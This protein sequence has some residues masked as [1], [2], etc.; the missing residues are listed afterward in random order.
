MKSENPS[1]AGLA[2]DSSES[3]TPGQGSL[4]ADPQNS[5]ER[6]ALCAIKWVA[7]QGGF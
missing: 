4:S 5:L 6:P 7:A 2:W 1:S 3:H